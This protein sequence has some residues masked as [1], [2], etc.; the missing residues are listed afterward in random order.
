MT[1]RS[2]DVRSGLVILA[3]AAI[4]ACVLVLHAA[5]PEP[6]I[7]VAGSIDLIVTA[8]LVAY[9]ARLS[10]RTVMLVASAGAIAARLFLLRSVVALAIAIEAAVLV[11]IAI[12]IRRA[13]AAWGL[14]RGTHFHDRLERALGATGIPARVADVLASEVAV[15]ANAVF[16]WRRRAPGGF[17]VH[18]SWAIYAG[19]FVGLTLVEAAL[20]HL[21]LVA[22]GAPIAAWIASALSL[23][24]ALWL[25]GDLHALRHGGVFVHG[26]ELELRIGVRWRARISRASI[27][28]ITRGAA[29]EDARDLSI[30]GANVVITLAEPCTLH[31]LFGIRRT[32]RVLALSL[33]DADGFVATAA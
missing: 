15:L 10:K 5:R 19:T 2:F 33:D 13:R 22:A 1:A 30:L 3:I 14:A 24:G 20:V 29:P 16:G 9:F 18:G 26:D 7:A 28:S 6:V 17:S 27:V 8:T 21:A 11:V 23:Y 31:G 25:L 12:R 32:A 4:W